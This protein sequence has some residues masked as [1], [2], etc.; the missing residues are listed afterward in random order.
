MSE[1]YA[2][3]RSILGYLIGRTVTDVTQHDKDEWDSEKACYIM[4]MFDDGSWLKVPVGNDGFDH[5]GE[6]E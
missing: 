1:S 5:S 6:E 2:N 4:L 3:I